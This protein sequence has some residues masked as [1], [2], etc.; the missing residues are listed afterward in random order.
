M[1][2]GR[3]GRGKKWASKIGLA[4]KGEIWETGSFSFSAALF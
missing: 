1:A 3:E 2:R 4:Y